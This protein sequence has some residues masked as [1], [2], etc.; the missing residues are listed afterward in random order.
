MKSVSRILSLVLL[1]LVICG[2]PTAAGQ[3]TG[4]TTQALIAATNDV[5]T[6]VAN[7]TVRLAGQGRLCTGTLIAPQIVITAGHCGFYDGRVGWRPDHWYNVQIQGIRVVAQFGPNS[8]NYRDQIPVTHI[9]ISGNRDL[10]LHALAR[11]PDPSVA[12]P[13]SPLLYYLPADALSDP[14]GF[15][16]AQ[17]F[18]VAGWGGQDPNSHSGNLATVRQTASASGAILDCNVGWPD[19]IC[20]RS[21]L[22][23]QSQTRGGDSGGPLYWTDPAGG[24]YLVG[25]LQG[26]GPQGDRYHYTWSDYQ[27]GWPIDQ[28]N[29]PG[30]LIN[31]TQRDWI[32]NA[33][34]RS[35][36]SIL[37]KRVAR[38]ARMRSLYLW[39]NAT[40]R[41]NYA[42][43]D[44]DWAGC[45]GDQRGSYA[46]AGALGLI[47]NPDLPQ[48]AGTIP[49]Y[50]WQSLSRHDY[51]LTSDPRWAGRP[52]DTRSPDYRFV[53][54]E[55]YIYPP[56]FSGNR[57]S[58]RPL[59]SWWSSEREDN[60]ATTDERWSPNETGSESLTSRRDG[61]R[62][63]RLEGYLMDDAPGT[64]LD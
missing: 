44:P 41:D 63:Y 15:W 23:G 13:R 57:D 1:A 50:Q 35:F 29:P 33:I 53:R 46:F 8:A 10:Q 52:G 36:C 18:T 16:A 6:P 17:R 34:G 56:D 58:L 22:S 32:R 31:L 48:P 49:L 4:S 7:S 20:V 28:G 5:D 64:T 24:S 42:T 12:V 30:Q 9:N 14:A 55:G 2:A 43:A 21:G 3:E 61:Y 47:F 19:A 59:W 39:W 62:Y 27:L 38:S 26:Y 60:F 45:E 37:R 40:Y 11:A 25:I 54:L 51:F